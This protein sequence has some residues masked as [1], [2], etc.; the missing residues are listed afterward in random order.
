MRVCIA[1]MQENRSLELVSFSFVKLSLKTA[2]WT[3]M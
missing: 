3:E 2:F 1:E